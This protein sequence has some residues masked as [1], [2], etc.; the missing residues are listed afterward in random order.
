M[1]HNATT[2]SLRERA[3]LPVA[4]SIMPS[5]PRVF[6][7]SSTESKEFAY[8]IQENLQPAIECV[9]WD[10]GIFLPNH[11]VL[12][13]LLRHVQQF[14]FGIFLLLADDRLEIRSQPTL[15]A[16]DNVI[17]ELGLFTGALGR[18]R[19]FMV[20]ADN[21]PDLHLPTDLLGI[22]TQTFDAARADNNWRAA[23][24]PA[25]AQLKKR[26]TDIGPLNTRQLTDTEGSAVKNAAAICFQMTNGTP[27]FLLINTTQSRRMFPKKK[28]RSGET[29]AEAAVECAFAE[30]GVYGRPVS[31]E[32]MIF[33]YFKSEEKVEQSVAA[34]IVEKTFSV[35]V[36]AN[37]FRDPKWFRLK[38][39]ER[40]LVHDRDFPYGN[41]LTKVAE[42]AARQI[43][44]LRRRRIQAGV[45]PFRVSAGK[46]E[47]L[48]ITSRTN[49]NWIL[50]KGNSEPGV[51]LKEVA[52]EEAFEEAGVTGSVLEER[53]GQYTYVHESVE[54]VF[55]VFAMEVATEHESWPQKSQ[56][57]RRWTEVDEAMA[58]VEYGHLRQT[59]TDFSR[60]MMARPSAV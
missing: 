40:E 6:I 39:L 15:G 32:S 41:E 45:V 20:K 26:I 9:V 5:K 58:L 43:R 11:T 18:F 47:V 31:G 35:D 3:R 28:I 24:G 44:Q 57:E 16:R 19:T 54:Y 59:L 53:I 52:Y 29:A 4:R 49:K 1:S 37:R 13:E 14:D 36:R 8:A 7:G 2:P 17:F 27:E 10:Q 22:L 33:K 21:V 25:C 38:E 48:L 12:E 34:I 51:S 50:P 42:W 46:L 30:G 60:K 56:R 23:L 55:D